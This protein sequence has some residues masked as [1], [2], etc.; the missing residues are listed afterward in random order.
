[1]EHV[2]I[3]PGTPRL[4]GKVERSHLTD[5]REFYQL[6]EYKNDVDIEEKLKEW[7]NFY[8][9]YRPHRSLQGKTPYQALM[10]KVALIKYV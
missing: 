10:D 7:E 8:N 5:K 9:F 4:N 1:M 3:K 2:Y 6:L